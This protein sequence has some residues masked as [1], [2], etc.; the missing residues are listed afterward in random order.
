MKYSL[1]KL[2]LNEYTDKTINQMAALYKPQTN[3]S[4]D[5]I[6]RNIVRYGE[7]IPSVEA[8]RWLVYMKSIPCLMFQGENYSNLHHQS[9]EP[10]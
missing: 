9:Q 5:Q 3:D 1:I 4:E 6:K 8:P 10:R 7:L 2:L